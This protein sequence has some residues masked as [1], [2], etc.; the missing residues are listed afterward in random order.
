MGNSPLLKPLHKHTCT[1]A[2]ILLFLETLLWE[3][4]KSSSESLAWLCL[5]T[6]H[7]KHSFQ[8]RVWV[9]EVTQEREAGSRWTCG[10]SEWNGLGGHVAL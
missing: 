6:W 10:G 7:G 8:V 1:T 2:P 9:T 5:L 3:S 4:N